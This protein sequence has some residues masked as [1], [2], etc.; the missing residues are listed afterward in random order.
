MEPV[1]T[2]LGQYWPAVMVVVAQKAG[3]QLGIGAGQVSAVAT[4]VVGRIADVADCMAV[5]A[6]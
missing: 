1:G 3:G 4:A 5:A 6:H 2:R